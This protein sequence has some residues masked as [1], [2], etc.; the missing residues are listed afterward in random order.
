MFEA[1]CVSV[2]SQYAQKVSRNRRSTARRGNVGTGSSRIA[3]AREQP[4]FSIV[5]CMPQKG[6]GSII[7]SIQMNSVFLFVSNQNHPRV[8]SYADKKQRHKNVPLATGDAGQNQ[9]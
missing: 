3:L 9:L 4:C 2:L 1:R 7:L 6:F 5:V 8:Q